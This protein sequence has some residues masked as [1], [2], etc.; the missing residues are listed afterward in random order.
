NITARERGLQRRDGGQGPGPTS[1]SAV[2][3]TIRNSL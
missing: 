2:P 3:L 1:R